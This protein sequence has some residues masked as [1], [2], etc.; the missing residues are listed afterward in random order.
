MVA[1]RPRLP[2]S[3]SDKPLC[4]KPGLCNTK[5][6][7]SCFSGGVPASDRAFDVLCVSKAK[8][9]GWPSRY[10]HCKLQFAI[11]GVSLEG[12]ISSSGNFLASIM[13]QDTHERR[14]KK[15]TQKQKLSEPAGMDIKGTVPGEGPTGLMIF[16]PRI[17]PL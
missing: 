14:K 4:S 15:Q 3:T 6:I 12:D 7:E 9:T 2:A 16:F 17:G 10:S 5:L 1:L 13:A 8:S 11:A